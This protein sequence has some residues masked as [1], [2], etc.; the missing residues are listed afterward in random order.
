MALV[1]IHAVVHVT[2]DVAMIAIRVRLGVAVRA[3]EDVVV[4]R[5]CMT[6]RADPVGVTVIHR[7]PRVIEGCSQPTR[8]RVTGG[9]S[10]R[11]PRGHVIRIVRA[12][13]IHLMTAEAVGG[14]RGVVV[15][16]MTASTR[17][18]RVLPSQ[19]EARV[20]VVEAGRTPG[21]R[22]VAHVALLREPGRNVVRIV[23]SFEV[24]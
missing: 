7:E 12:L 3:L 8:G 24:V 9:A 21:R 2:A 23:R 11:E 19:G 6:G 20:V 22:T 13:V 4:G 10:G 16:H 1:A 5:I 14:H 15:V 18:G 17:D